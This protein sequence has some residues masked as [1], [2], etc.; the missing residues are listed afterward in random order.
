M[1][2]YKTDEFGNTHQIE[3]HEFRYDPK[4][5]QDRYDIIPEKCREM[6]RLRY[7]TLVE[8][9]GFKPHTILDVGY[10]NGSFLD[11]CHA[12][13]CKTYG[14]DISTYPVSPEHSIIQS[15]K[16]LASLQ[17][18]A[19]TF[20]DSLEH[21]PQHL[22]FLTK[23]KAKCIMVSVP[24]YHP[25][26]GEAWFSSWKHRRPDEHLHHFSRSGLI[27]MFDSIGFK[28]LETTDIEDQIRG[29]Y[30]PGVENILTATFLARA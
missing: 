27:K 8:S 7:K 26:L 15:E 5:V 30:S 22:E 11:E 1:Q 20:F 28:C 25:E 14:Y 12:N 16:V 10:G 17:F 9:A 21:I 2:N 29:E 4:Y 24:W 13:G 6:S 3:R 18:D 23:L 19:I